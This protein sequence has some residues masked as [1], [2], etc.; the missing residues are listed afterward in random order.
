MGPG[1]D[2]IATVLSIHVA[3]KLLLLLLFNLFLSLTHFTAFSF[4]RLLHCSPNLTPMAVAHHLL[5]LPPRISILPSSF[6]SSSSSFSL[7]PLSSSSSPLCAKTSKLSVFPGLLK[8]GHKGNWLVPPHEITR[9][10][11]AFCSGFRHC[12]SA[13]LIYVF[14]R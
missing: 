5:A 6:S 14:P 11:V 2:R 3:P 12:V 7:L 8:L 13:P 1:V 4:W 9:F 10:R